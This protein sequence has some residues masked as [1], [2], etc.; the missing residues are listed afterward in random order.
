MPTPETVFLKLGGSL[1]T[2]KTQRETPRMDVLERLAGEIAGARRR[3]PEMRLLIGHGSGSFGHFAGKKYHTRDGIIAGQEERSWY[4]YAQ[5]GAAAARLNRLVIDALLD[6]GL[7]AVTIQ[8]SATAQCRD[9]DLLEM[10]WLPIRHALDV[11]LLPVVHGDVAMDTE[12]G[13]TIIS[14]EEIFAYLAG[15]IAPDRILLAGTVDGVFTGDPLRD[16]G[17]EQISTIRAGEREIWERVLS[18]SHGVDVTGGMAAKVA[19]M[20][21]LVMA[22]SSLIVQILSGENAGALGQALLDP[23]ANAGTRIVH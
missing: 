1:I 11:G 5:T 2:D 10:H 14:T 20:A 19:D 13:C 15:Q 9:G 4:G 8:P 12:R 23:D 6:V 7:P 16:E 3:R 22:Y 18:G 21:D 17:V